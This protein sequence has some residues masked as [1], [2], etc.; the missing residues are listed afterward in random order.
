MNSLQ[1]TA[2]TIECTVYKVQCT[3]Y[4]VPPSPATGPLTS[5]PKSPK[6]TKLQIINEVLF[7]KI[8]DNFITNIDIHSV[9]LKHDFYFHYIDIFL[10]N[11]YSRK[12][13]EIS[14]A[15]TGNAIL[16]TEN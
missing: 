14:R 2:Y 7:V 6:Q 8:Y 3:V 15:M 4:T 10:E 1:F 11:W 5:K 9:Q 13:K 16:S 12:I